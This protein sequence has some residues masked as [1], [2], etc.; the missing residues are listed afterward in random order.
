[1]PIM[2]RKTLKGEFRRHKISKLNLQV[3]VG[4]RDRG[5][6][7][8]R[9]GYDRAPFFAGAHFGTGGWIGHGKPYTGASKMHGT[10]AYGKNPRTALAGAL[11]RVVKHLSGR[12]GAFA[13]FTGYSKRKGVVWG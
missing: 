13:A 12:K 1:M 2:L 4:R 11:R 6:T 8:H 5:G 7:G 10:C 3:R 9:A